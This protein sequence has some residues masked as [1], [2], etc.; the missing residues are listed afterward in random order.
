VT[1]TLGTEVIITVP[2]AIT[3]AG[4]SVTPK[5][6]VALSING[7]ITIAGQSV[8]LALPL[9]TTITTPGAITIAGQFVEPWLA[10]PPPNLVRN[11]TPRCRRIPSARDRFLARVERMPVRRRYGT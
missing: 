11:T 7:A 8:T 1:M 6:E 10:S 3:V 5:I 9:G 4:Q 2:G